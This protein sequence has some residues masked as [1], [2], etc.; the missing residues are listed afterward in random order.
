MPMNR[1][2]FSSRT[3]RKIRRIRKKKVHGKRER[4]TL[5]SLRI[6]RKGARISSHMSSIIIN[7][8]RGLL[9]LS[10]DKTTLDRKIP[11]RGLV[12]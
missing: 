10:S 2:G 6:S 12:N 4:I 3:I 7:L 8:K 1:S 5:I 11:H 9:R